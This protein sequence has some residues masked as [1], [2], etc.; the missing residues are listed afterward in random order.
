MRVFRGVI[1][2]F[3]QRRRERRE[4]QDPNISINSVPQSAGNEVGET[5]RLTLALIDVSTGPTSS[6]V[7]VDIP[8]S[9]RYELERGAVG[10]GED[11]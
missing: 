2:D 7:D 8:D 1:L 9:K 4:L 6:P 3:Q 10:G 11:R 5:F